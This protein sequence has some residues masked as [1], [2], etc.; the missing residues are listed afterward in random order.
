MN[1]ICLPKIKTADS[2]H[3]AWAWVWSYPI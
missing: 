1:V 3:M 2:T